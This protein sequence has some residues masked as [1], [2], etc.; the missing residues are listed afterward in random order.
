M[1]GECYFNTETLKLPSFRTTISVLYMTTSVTAI[2]LNALVLIS[3]FKTESL[4]KPSFAL[5]ANLAVVDLM[6]GSVAEPL[7]FVTNIAALYGWSNVFCICSLT[8]RVVGYWLGSVSLYTLVVI[9]VDRFL[10]IRLKNRYRTVVTMKRVKAALMTWWITVFIAV[11]SAFV[12]HGSIRTLVSVVGTGVFVLLL[13]LSLSYAMSFHYL[14]K[15]STSVAS[16]DIERE[17]TGCNFNPLRYRR[18]LK[19]MLLLFGNIMLFFLPFFCAAATLVVKKVE[20]FDENPTSILVYKL[21]MTSEFIVALNSTVNPLMYIWRIKD[22]RG[23]M[24]N[25]L[26]KLVGLTVI[27][28]QN[29]PSN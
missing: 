19:T 9:S 2:S 14:K 22:L 18:S 25:T 1:N 10:A 27:T 6:A 8:A 29:E 12:F 23:A 20:K 24:K 3:I 15:L 28:D 26:R 17:R 13:I 11:L 5:L 4:H 7:I 16:T 21:L